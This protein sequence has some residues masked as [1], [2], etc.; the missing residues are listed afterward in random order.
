[1]QLHKQEKGKKEI[2]RILGISKNTVKAYLEKLSLM[3]LGIDALLLLDDP[4]LEA[5]F[6]PGNPAY[7]DDRFQQLKNKLDDYVTELKRPGVT[8]QL[9]WE[10]YHQEFPVGYRPT[11]FY[12]HLSQH[13]AARNPSMVLQHKPGEKLFVD[14]AGKKL[15]TVDRD[16]GEII[17]HQVFVA[18]MPYSDYGFSMAIKSQGIA[19]FL[20]TLACCLEDLEGVPELIVPD[21]LK[22]AVT[23]ANR[24][25]PTISR[26]LEDFANHYGTTILPTRAQKPKDKALVE[27]QV[28]L[29]Y[30]RVYAKLRNELFFD[31]ASL[32][33][34]IKE[35]M[36]DH[37][38]TRMQQK[39]FSR[40]EN[41]LAN[42][43][44]LL[45]PLPIEAFELK[46]YCDLT[47][48]KNNHIYLG[49]D[50]HYYSVPYSHI[51]ARA[52]VIFTRSMVRI[53]VS[54][55]QVAVHQRNYKMGSYTTVKDHLCS[56]H[57]HYLDRSPDYY[58]KRAKSKGEEFYQLISETFLQG[59]HPEQLYRI[60]DGLFNLEK[61]TD[62]EKFR[63]ACLLALELKNYSFHFLSNIIKNNMATYHENKE[64]N[65]NL[66][67]HGNIRGRDYYVQTELK[68]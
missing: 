8:R 66:P 23:K 27:N 57:R 25:E 41:F 17:E 42:E 35:K 49:I 58:M 22:S 1:L 24:Y 15:S 6:H 13:I 34:A 63:E 19:D 60:C 38:Q 14:Y 39:P 33:F 9:L 10:E 56:A 4:E 55:Q 51:G 64:T 48:A 28:K 61:K 16:T 46:S 43:K 18:C 59:K 30:T 2:A 11:Q 68:F 3:K 31:L 26:A 40:E 45:R 53:Y 20:H 32:N 37:N 21:N 7:S 47:V 65:K 5:H 44:P 36:K 50:K 62:P 12:F 52:K 29:I 67:I 54:G